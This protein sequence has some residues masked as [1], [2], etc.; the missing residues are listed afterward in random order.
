MKSED[1]EWAS[2][3]QSYLEQ[4]GRF[5][6]WSFDDLQEVIAGCKIVQANGFRNSPSRG[7]ILY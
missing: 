6:D 1:P 7:I 5:P 2:Q 3:F 4:G